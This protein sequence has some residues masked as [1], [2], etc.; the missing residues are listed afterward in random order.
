MKHILAGIIL[1]IF[2]AGISAQELD[3]LKAIMKKKTSPETTENRDSLNFTPVIVEE[4]G[5][6]VKIQVFKKEIIKVVDTGDSTY[7][8]LG[9]RKFV[10]IKDHPDSTMIRVGDKE[11]KIV[12]K[13][14]NPKISIDDVK[15]EPEG[16]PRF[17]GHWA[18]FEW[19]INN[20]MDEDFTISREGDNQFMDINTSRSWVVNLNLAQF[21]LGF[22]TSHAG[23]LTGI[24][25]EF[26]NYF[27]DRDNTITE[28]NDR[29]VEFN[30]PD[31]NV[32]KSKLASTFL[33]I[34]L[35]LEAQFP[36]VIRAKRVFLSGGLI[37]GLKLGSKTKVVYKDGSGKNR[38]KIRDDFNISPLRYGLT[39]RIGYGNLN[40]FGDYYF[41]PMFVADKGPEL[42]PFSL[43][44]SVTF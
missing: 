40:V 16:H 19:G 34:P 22:G 2:T 33:R 9:D 15:D 39:A 41:T 20:F 25:L 8:K 12:E 28:V 44:L 5:D 26:N 23:I 10:E 18:G 24:G 4:N 17:R 43:G 14:N 11:I 35:I 36:R 29:V 32:T 1:A 30:L 3:S 42:Y 13:E 37:T 38:D 7:I 27:F 21:S 31:V 6:E